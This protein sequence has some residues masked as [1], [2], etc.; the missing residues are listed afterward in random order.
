MARPTEPQERHAVWIGVLLVV[1]LA[2]CS[3]AVSPSPSLSLSPSPSPTTVAQPSARPAPIEGPAIAFH[4]DPDG[5]DDFYLIGADGKGLQPLTTNAETVAFPYWSPDGTRIAYLCCSGFDASLWVMN[6]DGSDA[7][8]LTTGRAGSPAWS[9]DG[10]RIAYDDHDDGAIWVVG[11]DG[12]GARRLADDSGGPSWS[13]DGTNIVFFS[14]R[15]Y[16]GEEQ[17]NELYMMD[18]NGSNQVR[19]TSN[20]AED[21]EPRWSPDGMRIA[22]TSSRDG[23]P[24]IYLASADGSGQRPLTNDAVPD[25]GPAWSPDGSRIVFTSYRDGADPLTLGSGN[26]EIFTVDPE[27]SAPTS[28]TSDPGWDGYPAWSPDG[29]QLAFSNNNGVEFDLYVMNADGTVKRRLAGVVGA[30]GIAS[31]CCPAWRP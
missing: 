21:V 6:A 19:L 4:A 31:D 17:R 20:E 23:N 28:L 3:P 15:D 27:G 30:N 13:P 16:P 26:A 29:G 5:N 11:A 10:R 7:R 2:A 18:A 22:F 24:D 14:W 8:R 12:S 25:E 9:P 1:V